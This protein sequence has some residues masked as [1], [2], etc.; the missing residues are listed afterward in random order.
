MSRFSLAR[1]FVVVSS[2]CLALAACSGEPSE[3]D[4][5][6]AVEQAY[7]SVNAQ[8]G[9]VGKLIGKDLSTKVKSF[10]K[11]ACSEAKGNPGFACDFQMVVDGPLGE[12]TENASARFVKGDKGWA[13]FGM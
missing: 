13:I 3:S 10:K 1:S 5:K 2:A 9:G 4:M 11:L 6:A 8:L 7:G 12:K